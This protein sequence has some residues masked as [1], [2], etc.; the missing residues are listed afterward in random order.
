M[1]DF[2]RAFQRLMDDEGIEL[3]NDAADRG[4]LTY[5][6]VTR[7][8]HPKWAGWKFIDAGSTP[9]LDLVRELYRTEYWE[10]VRADQI[11]SQPVA[12][13]LFS[14]FANMGAPAIKLIQACVNVIQ[15]GKVGPKTLTAINRYP[16]TYLLMMYA[17]V[18]IKRYHAIGMKD[19]TQRKF[20]PGWIAR[21]LRIAEVKE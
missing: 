12:E 11:T 21:G 19:K 13:C 3:T 15:D 5:A 16:E 1:A 6:G 20:W 7:K 17:L 2:E 18:N 8:N 4:G 14:Q 10:P 9:P